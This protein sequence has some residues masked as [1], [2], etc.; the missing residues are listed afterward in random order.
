MKGCLQN[1]IA[2]VVVAVVCL[3]LLGWCSM[4]VLEEVANAP[5]PPPSAADRAMAETD[6]SDEM[7]AEREAFVAKLIEDG[8][9]AK[10]DRP[11]SMLR[12]YPRPLFMAADFDDKESILS[13]VWLW[14]HRDDPDPFEPIA[15]YDPVTDEELGTYSPELGLRLR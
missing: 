3:G 2:L 14:E 10:V 6:F 7:H 9:I 4:E 11:G 1:L 8:L 5:P 15:L 13:V 12:V